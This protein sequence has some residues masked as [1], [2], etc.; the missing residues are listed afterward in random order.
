M[1]KE[2]KRKKSRLG[3]EEGED[4]LSILVGMDGGVVDK[5]AWKNN[6]TA[7]LIAKS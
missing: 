3:I 5:L 1:K 6:G 4:S 7:G 2:K